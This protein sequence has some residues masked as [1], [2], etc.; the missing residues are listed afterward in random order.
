MDVSESMALEKQ[1]TATDTEDADTS[2]SEA[3]HGKIDSFFSG[4]GLSPFSAKIAKAYFQSQLTKEGGDVK[5]SRVMQYLLNSI[6]NRHVVSENPLQRGCPGIIP[7]LTATPLWNVDDTRLGFVQMLEENFSVIKEEFM[8]ARSSSSTGF[9]PYR[10]PTASSS[11]N[12]RDELGYQATD[13]GEWNIAYLFLHGLNFEDNQSLFPKTCA[14]VKSLPR[15]YCH[16]FFSVLT[17]GTRVSPHFGPTNRKIRC[18]F[19]II[20]PSE[21]YSQDGL[22]CCRLVVGGETAVLHEGRCVVFDDSFEHETVNLSSSGAAPRVVLIV[23]FWHPDFTDEEVKFL[24]YINKAQTNAAIKMSIAHHQETGTGIINIHTREESAQ[25]A[26]GG[27]FFDVIENV[28][29]LSANT[30]NPNSIWGNVV[31]D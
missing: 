17:P 16:A 3:V 28:R 9:Q 2:R 26:V 29:K 1:G 23:D 25:S 5:F 10:A 14:V 11:S 4:I 30:V 6:S 22:P 13:T 27:T 18:H 7:G 19:P 31:D 12:V 8:A 15:Q 24:E 20:V 21:N